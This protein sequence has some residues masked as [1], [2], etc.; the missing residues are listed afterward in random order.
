MIERLVALFILLLVSPVLFILL[1]ITAIDLGANPIYVQ[2][3]TVDGTRVFWF[4]KIRSMK[5][6]APL[7]SSFDFLESEKYIT[8]WGRFI[9]GYSLDELLN[10]FCICKGDM[11]FIGPRPV[12]ISERSLIN[13]RVQHG[14]KGLPG[15]T[16]FAQ[17]NGRDLVSLDQKV[18]YEKVYSLKKGSLLLR[19]YIILK[20]L[21]IVI[22]KIGIRH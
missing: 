3:R 19:C 9:R 6:N 15:L 4:Y 22:C 18:F 7:L 13:L 1:L 2:L 10:L 17:V 14:I 21:Q 11:K 16:G 8:R 5:L 12:I 20:T